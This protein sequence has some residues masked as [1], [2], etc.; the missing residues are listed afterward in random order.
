MAIK[1]EIQK[2]PEVKPLIYVFK[3]DAFP[4]QLKI[5]YTTRSAEIRK[6]EWP[7]DPNWHK[8]K[9]IF[10]EPAVKDD[11]S[12]FMDHQIH[13]DLER[14][15]FKRIEKEWFEC[16]FEEFKASYIAVKTGT[17]NEEE[18][19]LDFE[20]RIEQEKAIQKTVNHFKNEPDGRKKF[21]WNCKMRFGKTFTS[22]KLAKKMNWNKVLVLTF[23]PAVENS[24]KDDLKNHID[25]EG[26]QFI[27]KGGLRYDNIDKDKPFVCFGSFQDFLG[28]NANGGIKKKNRWA[29]KI[30]WD[31]I[32]YDEYHFGAWRET[33][34]ELIKAEINEKSGQQALYDEIME[35]DGLIPIKTSHELYLSGTPFRAISTGEFIEDEIFN[36]T[37]TDEQEIKKK[38][39]NKKDNPY[40]A[41]PKMTMFTYK[42]P[43]EIRKIA[44]EEDY[45]EF[46]LS[47]FFSVDKEKYTPSNIT[48]AKFKFEN[49][50]Q[51]WLDWL[52]GKTLDPTI[53]QNPPLPFYQLELL[54]NLIHT[55]WFL[56]SVASCYAMKNLL[57]Q[58]QNSFF[59]EYKVLICA[60]NEVGTGVKALDPV[61][62]AI[63]DPSA[64]DTKTVT[65]TCGKLL[66]GVTVPPWTGIFMLRNLQSPETYFQAAFRTQNQWTCN[67]EEGQEKR[68]L[69]LKH[70]CYVFDFAPNRGLKLASDYACKLKTG[71]NHKK[72]IEELIKFLPVYCYDNNEMHRFDAKDILNWINCGTTSTLLAQK[73]KSPLLVKLN[74]DRMNSLLDRPH[75]VEALDNIIELEIFAKLKLNWKKDLVVMINK[76]KEIKKVKSKQKKLT[77]T[78]KR[79]LNEEEKSLRNMM[80]NYRDALYVIM[81]RLPIFMYLTDYREESI[82]DLIT[83]VEPNLFKEVTYLHVRIFEELV[84]IG[85][86]DGAWLNE[87]V[88]N[89]RDYED[90]SLA[91]TGIT[92]HKLDTVGLFDTT[93]TK[94]EGKKVYG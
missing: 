19:I 2:R 7:R 58:N 50:V 87:V 69:I 94:D 1:L 68:K 64:L 44:I 26:W 45:N 74:I 8:Y 41:L 91:Y 20:P 61:E 70:E 28:K 60:G 84:D 9:C 32:I 38:Y 29:H 93:I 57:E 48:K 22:Y 17:F 24:W 89:F 11:G 59:R 25:F 55:I 43:E 65:L 90:A 62:A 82:T 73:L 23:K 4:N 47:S 77:K 34:K 66:T 37:Y 86:F 5:G 49:E 56:P 88:W 36:W 72:N 78:E 79:T 92:K 31:C 39:K 6:N 71:L 13:N 3:N 15:S 76:N 54:H 21:L 75:L 12:N 46:D 33:A 80:G 30:E 35:N 53:Q 67:G 18:R 27:S 10:E 52:R 14:R 51:Q 63:Y 85:L 42:V 83:K 16:T 40:A 81:N